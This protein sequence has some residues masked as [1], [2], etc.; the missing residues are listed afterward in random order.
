[1]EQGI[2]AKVE[3]KKTRKLRRP[4]FIMIGIVVVVVVVVLG[5]LFATGFKTPSNCATGIYLKIMN[6]SMY[7]KNPY[8]Y[9]VYY[10]FTKQINKS[11]TNP[12]FTCS[13]IPQTKQLIMVLFYN[14][15][16]NT[17]NIYP[18]GNVR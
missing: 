14:G 12:Y 2:Q 16:N 6:G 1:M 10:N 5:V 13:Y 9:T 15:T 3:T 7:I 4:H 11:I 8:N 17:A 18:K